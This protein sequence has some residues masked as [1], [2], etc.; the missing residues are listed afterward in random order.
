MLIKNFEE[1][2]Q[3]EFA[4]VMLIYWGQDPDLLKQ[5]EG[6][7]LKRKIWNYLRTWEMSRDDLWL[8]PK[9]PKSFFEELSSLRLECQK[10]GLLAPGFELSEDQIKR[11]EA[12]KDARHKVL[13]GSC[14]FSFQLF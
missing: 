12:W 14:K 13:I 3:K 8:L 4:N 2:T 1:L 5:K 9:R 10:A 11:D 7:H 6:L